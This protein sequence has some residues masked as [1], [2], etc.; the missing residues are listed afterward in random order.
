MET[1]TQNVA[2]ANELFARAKAAI[3]TD[4]EARGIGAI[5]WDNST[6]GF[7]QLP[8]IL[9]VSTRTGKER[10]ARIEG[11]YN[12]EGEVYLIEEDRADVNIDNFYN[13]NTEVKPTVVTLSPDMAVK[14]LGNPDDERG[15]TR[16]GSLE[17]WT[18]ITDCY[19]EALAEQ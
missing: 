13:K 14:S 12:Y 1:N 18:V 11:L 6:A 2:A 19:Y 8:E 17:E 16:Q 15:Y 4:M 7:H 9:H 3:A 10:V 5:I